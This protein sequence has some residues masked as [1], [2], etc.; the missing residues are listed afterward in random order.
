M[1]LHAII[2]PNMKTPKH[3]GNLYDEKMIGYIIY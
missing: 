1:L 2:N 3:A